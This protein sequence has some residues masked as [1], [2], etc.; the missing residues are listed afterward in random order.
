MKKIFTL[1]ALLAGAATLQ[2]QS[3][4]F[5]D[6]NG[7]TIADGSTLTMNNAFMDPIFEEWML[8]LE[9]VSIKNSGASEATANVTVKATTLP[10]GSFACCLGESCKNINEQGGTITVS[11]P[12]AANGTQAFA[13]TEWM[14]EEGNYGTTVVTFTLSGGPSITVN[15]VYSESASLGTTK[16]D[17]Q[18]VAY[19]SLLGEKLEKPVSGINIVQYAN[20]KTCRKVIKK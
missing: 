15:F 19:Y 8:P 5:V 16:A 2:A 9:G 17:D 7:A 18:I 3:L 10:S 13:N 4:S 12:V 1:F 20:G 6:A 11:C 14:L